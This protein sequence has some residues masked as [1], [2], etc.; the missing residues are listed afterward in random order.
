MNSDFLFFFSNLHFVFS[1]L[2][3]S[4]NT[5]LLKL[6]SLVVE[7]VEKLFKGKVVSVYKNFVKLVRQLIKYRKVCCES[8]YA[9]EWRQLGVN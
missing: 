8:K 2:T 1:F 4:H 3:V 7:K 6:I 5:T 9:Q